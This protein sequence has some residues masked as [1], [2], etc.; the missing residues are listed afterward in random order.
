MRLSAIVAVQNGAEHLASALSSIRAQTRPADEVLVVD[1][2]STDGTEAVARSFP[3]VRYLRQRGRGLA[4]ARN[5]GIAEA[6]GELLAFLDHDDLWTPD[7]LAVQVAVLEARPE[8]LFCVAH[9][10]QFDD[11]A[12]LDEATRPGLT[13]G[14]LVARRAA[15]ER[16]GGFDPAFSIGCDSEWF[17]RARDLRVPSVCVPQA[18]LL[19]RRRAASLSADRETYRRE[20]LRILQ[21]SLARRG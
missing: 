19:K 8:L 6:S 3:Q 11:P 1:G 2:E 10:R 17:I 9:W 18:L 16:L 7:K 21:K 15:F 4:E 5:T 20:W 12:A 14:S 13:P